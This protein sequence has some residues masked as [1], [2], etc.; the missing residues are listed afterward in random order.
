M[1][2][3]EYPK[4]STC[5]NA[6]K[7]LLNHNIDFIDRHIVENRPTYEELL[8]WIVESKLPIKN[9]FNTSG[10][11]YKEKNLKEII[12]TLTLEDAAKLLSE[13]GMLVKRPILI[14]EDRIILGYSEEKYKL[15]FEKK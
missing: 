3:I 15:F 10:K 5:R 12:S 11:L 4:C 14:D 8:N 6:K 1:L 13:N 9:F 7:Y 2:F